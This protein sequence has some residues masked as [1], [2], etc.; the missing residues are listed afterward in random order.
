MDGPLETGL[1]LERRSVL[2]LFDTDDLQEGIAAFFEKR[3]PK[4][5]GR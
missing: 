2:T 1:A 4:Y 5:S 3:D